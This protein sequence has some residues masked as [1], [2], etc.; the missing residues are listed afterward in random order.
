MRCSWSRQLVGL[1]LV[2]ALTGCA[3]SAPSTADSSKLGVVA[4]F[5]PLAWMA[6]QIGGDA[7]AVTNLTP[8]GVE[9]HD[10]ELAPDQVERLANADLAIVLGRQFQP[11]PEKVASRRKGPTVTVLSRDEADTDPHIWLDPVR[12]SDVRTEIVAALSA[13]RP[14]EADGF[15]E[16]SAT[17]GQRLDA[18]DDEYRAGLTTCTRRLIVS[19]HAAFGRLAKRYGLVQEGIAGLSPDAEPDP[20]RLADLADLVRSSGA[21]TVF[22]EDMAPKEFAQTVA[23]EVGV[24]TQVLSPIEGLTA[25][26]LTRGG[27]YLTVMG[28]NLSA[29]QLALGCTT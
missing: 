23:R 12:F 14:S 3:S 9:P 16:R 27:S 17:L 18:L 15:R 5:Y 20:Q 13:L 1:A 10:L 4:T 8:P 7:V 24:S 11:G 29:L 6:E 19:T 25:D 2:A 21:T 28:D 22:T 26:Q